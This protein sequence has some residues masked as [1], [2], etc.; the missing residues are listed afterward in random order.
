[1]SFLSS[2][3]FVNK[4]MLVLSIW[5][6]S[7]SPSFEYLRYKKVFL[8]GNKKNRHEKNPKSPKIQKFL[9]AKIS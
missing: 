6:I 7:Y 3:D 1:M 9:L 5:V 2:Q 4:T 8:D